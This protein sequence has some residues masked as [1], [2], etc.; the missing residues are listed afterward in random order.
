M[1]IDDFITRGYTLSHM[2]QA[3][4]DTNP[5]ISVYGIALAKTDRREYHRKLYG[6]EL[7]NNHIPPKW[8]TL[9]NQGEE[10]YRSMRKKVNS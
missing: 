7:S 5:E 2:A 1:I 10:Q 8:E 3:I 4:Q 9:W 6:K